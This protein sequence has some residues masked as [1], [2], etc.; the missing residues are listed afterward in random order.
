[1]ENWLVSKFLIWEDMEQIRNQESGRIMVT[2]WNVPAQDL[3]LCFL[4]KT[5]E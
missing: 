4:A 1:M 3:S 5:G 2:A